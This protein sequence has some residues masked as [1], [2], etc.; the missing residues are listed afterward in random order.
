MTKQNGVGKNIAR[1]FLSLILFFLLLMVIFC[2][3]FYYD[4]THLYHS[5][6]QGCSY[7]PWPEIHSLEERRIS[8]KEFS[9]VQNQKN[10]QKFNIICKEKL[11]NGLYVASFDDTIITNVRYNNEYIVAKG[12]YRPTG[13]ITYWIIIKTTGIVYGPFSYEKI[14]TFHLDGHKHLSYIINGF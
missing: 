1:I 12:I 13:E 9:V 3:I 5:L 14:N 8:F 2:A 4:E 11:P 10:N 7:A 6:G